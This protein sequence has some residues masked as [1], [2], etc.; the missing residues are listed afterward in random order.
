MTLVIKLC[1]YYSQQQLE[2]NKYLLGEEYMLPDGYL[3]VIITWLNLF[4]VDVTDLKNVSRFY[5]LMKERKSVQMSLTQEGI[6][7]K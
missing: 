5:E 2:N 1:Y 7:L 4:K 6:T 3:F